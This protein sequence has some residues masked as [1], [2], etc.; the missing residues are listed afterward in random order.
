MVGRVVTRP[1]CRGYGSDPEPVMHVRPGGVEGAK[2]E[3]Y[4]VL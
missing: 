4:V 3:E 1:I 2:L